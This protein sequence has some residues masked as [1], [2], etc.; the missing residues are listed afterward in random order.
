MVTHLRPTRAE[1]TDVATAIFD[2]ADATMLSA[3][4]ATGRFPV[5]TVEMMARIAER[6]ERAALSRQVE[7]RRPEAY[8]FSEAAAEAASQAASVLHAKAVVAF[9]QSGFTARLISEQRP[10]VP[11][12]ALTPFT[13]VRRK[14]GLFWGVSSRL[15]RQVETTDEMI[16]GVDATLLSDGT[17]QKN[18]V[19]VII[20]G[21]PT[22]VSGTTNLLKFHRVGEPS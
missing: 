16:Q 17:V 13:E 9:T 15:V 2:G 4:T 12:I 7:R 5:E 3:E 22:W 11:I 21:A 6:A 1:V 8:G 10:A 14:I 18:D 20:S 19:L